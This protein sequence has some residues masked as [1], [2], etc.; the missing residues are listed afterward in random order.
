[1]G[2]EIEQMEREVENMRKEWGDK[3]EVL[4][5]EKEVAEKKCSK[6]K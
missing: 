5:S 1:M 2:K 3:I 6:Y 4:K